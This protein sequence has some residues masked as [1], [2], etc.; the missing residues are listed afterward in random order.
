MSLE[1][2]TSISDDLSQIVNF[3]TPISDCDSHSH[4]LFD[5]FLSSDTS[6]CFTINFP[7]SGNSDHVVVSVSIGF[8]SYPRQ[9]ALFHRIACDYSCADGDVLCD[10]L[11]DV[12]WDNIFKLGASA[13]ASEFCESV[14]VRI[15]VYI[16][17]Q[18]YQVK[19]HLSPWFS[20]ACAAVI[21]HRNHFFCLYQ[22]DKSSQS[23]IKF[24]K[25]SSRCK[26]PNLHM[27]RK[28]NNFGKL[29]I[30]F[31]TKVKLLYFL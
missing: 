3:L 12:P 19:P 9:D 1:T 4:A 27:L 7:P 30:V 18:K 29:P 23:I 5:L 2:L 28:Q 6:I 20:A 25:A 24:R 14:Q 8:P 10:H 22:I 16:P 15:D 26:Q 31:S 17:Y 21:V 13:V 11:G